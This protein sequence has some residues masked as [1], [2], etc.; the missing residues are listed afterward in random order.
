MPRHGPVVAAVK[1]AAATIPA[2]RRH[3]GGSSQ[4]PAAPPRS[5][6]TCLDGAVGDTSAGGSEFN[7]ATSTSRTAG[8]P[9]VAS[10]LELK[11][12]AGLAGVRLLRA[13][14]RAAGLRER[15]STI[16]SPR[17]RRKERASTR[18]QSFIKSG[19]CIP[20]G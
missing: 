19:T 11:D 20:Q 1:P 15:R 16:S 18:H 12:G 5:R 7:R 2:T 6:V 3:G 17:M 13:G 10:E 14:L 8:P 9:L 4:T